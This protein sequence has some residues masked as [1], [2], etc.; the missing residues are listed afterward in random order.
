MGDEDSELRRDLISEANA[1]KPYEVELSD[2]RNVLL[3]SSILLS[4][5]N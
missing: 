2:L 1:L 5:R 4:V 3:R